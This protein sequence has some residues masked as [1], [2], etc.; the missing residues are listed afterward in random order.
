MS[1]KIDGLIEKHR[2]EYSSNLETGLAKLKR[3]IEDRF[4]CKELP[5]WGDQKKHVLDILYDLSIR[6]DTLFPGLDSSAE[7]IRSQYAGKGE[8]GQ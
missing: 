8:S 4:V 7:E 1:R 2:G 3:Q 6:K 5:V